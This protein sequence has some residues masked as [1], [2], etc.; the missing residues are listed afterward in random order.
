[1]RRRAPLNELSWLE[2]AG[3]NALGRG[4][5]AWPV[6][7]S[8]VS[9]LDAVERRELRTIERSAVLRA[10]IA[11]ALSAATTALVTMQVLE[12]EQTDAVRYWQWVGG[13]SA[14]TAVLEVAYL[15]WDSLKAVRQMAKSSGVTLYAG[16]ALNHGV[17]L[18]L[19]RAALE[20]RS[21]RSNP[22][23]VDPHREASR[24][25]LLA[26]SLLYKAKVAL[27]TFLL[28]AL[29][30]R[31]LGRLAAR[32]ALEFVAVPVTAIWNMVVCYRVLREARIRAMGPSLAKELARWIVGSEE[33]NGKNSSE[34]MRLVAWA[35]GTSIVKNQRVH[36]NWVAL[37]EHLDLPQHLEG[38]WGD[39]PR[40]LVTFKSADL[41]HQ[42]AALRALIAAALLDGRFSRLERQWLEVVFTVVGLPAPLA[43]V[44]HACHA[45]VAGDGFDPAPFQI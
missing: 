43:E 41:P 38:D 12:L 29:L 21:P 34:F 35:L 31:V 16:D 39:C 27:S 40:F 10:G 20:L 42:R 24:W 8:P 25:Q 22:L 30:R 14:I 1:M 15:Y 2:R 45:F 5:H 23:M 36:P 17:A 33:Y 37:I 18:S 9:E 7:T 3:L 4:A 11:G 19:A 44:A 13:A 28:K 26:A 32:A 6:P